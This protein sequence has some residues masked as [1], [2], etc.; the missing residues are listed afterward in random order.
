MASASQHVAAPLRRGVGTSRA[1]VGKHVLPVD[2]P[3]LRGARACCRAMR[4]RNAILAFCVAACGDNLAAQSP[5]ASTTGGT[6][7][8]PATGF[9]PVPTTNQPQVQKG[10]GTPLATPRIVPIF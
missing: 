3:Q 10:P 9:L 8:A 7:D 6:P 4:A 1:S 2:A 5:D